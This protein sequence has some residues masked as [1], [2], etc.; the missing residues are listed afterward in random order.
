MKDRFSHLLESQC[1]R[2]VARRR[3]RRLA[4]AA[5]AGLGLL[6]LLVPNRGASG[7]S[8]FADELTLQP[9][10]QES[11]DA[12]AKNTPTAPGDA[13]GEM[14]LEDLMNVQVTSVSR[15]AQKISEA[16]AA[17]TVITQD[18]I[19]RWG[20]HSIP[21][22]LRLAPGMSVARMDA[23]D[24]AIS[25]RG[26][27]DQYANKLLV[28]V[29]G[30]TVY[31][32]FYAGV[33]WDT[34]D[35]LMQDLERIE[36]IRGPGATLWGANA[37]NG[38]IN[39]QTKSA[40]DTQGVLV[41]GLGSN[42]D[43]VGAARYGGKIDDDTFFRLYGQFRKTEEFDETSGRGHFDGWQSTRGGFRI[44]RYGTDKDTL[45]LEG[46]AF[47]ELFGDRDT[48]ANPAFVPPFTTEAEST[49]YS[50]GQYVLG[51]WTHA[52]SDESEFSAQFY[53]DHFARQENELD[54]EQD[55]IDGEFQHRFPVG[56]IQSII[57]GA[58]VRFVS[59]STS[60]TLIADV[61][62]PNKQHYRLA[63]FAQDDVTVVPER[64]HFIVG[65]K[66]EYSSY[67]EFEYQPSARV[68]WTPHERH[69]VW[70]AIS[71]AVHTPTREVQDGTFLLQEFPGQGGVP[72]AVVTTPNRDEK[73]EELLAYELGYRVK[74]IDQ[75]TFDVA[76]FFNHYEGLR[77]IDNSTPQ[78]VPTPSPHVLVTAPAG[79][80][81]DA[82]SY[83]VEVGMNLNITRDWL[84]AA[85]YSFVDIRANPRS[86]ST[87]TNNEARIEGSS[88]QNQ[89]Q[90]HTSYRVTRDLELN[91]SAY[92]V[93]T[94]PFYDIPSY[95]RTDLGLSWRPK[96][97]LVLDVGVQNLFDNQHPEFGPGIVSLNAEVPRTVYAQLTWSF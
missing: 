42:V 92:Y 14:S 94:L 40:R 66:F 24:W 16:P 64:L 43:D 62:P 29:D 67:S 78:F 8:A 38:V 23:N 30:R 55:T 72:T 11:T 77:S 49:N 48:L 86:S 2:K 57:W 82:D 54:F 20:L 73:S 36:V 61:D 15:H 26:F 91:A 88:P 7:R 58:G 84:L 51:R 56:S 93:E 37:V 60:Q 28:L 41:T 18:D 75:L 3:R 89:A 13:L 76:T 85:S 22:A 87:D 5:A 71:R 53:Y 19:H 97:G 96:D 70:G 21:E 68:L 25:A 80:S 50:T 59:D 27:N 45:T 69:T 4:I 33:D 35:Y 44:D 32:P 9:A 12:G 74:P 83:G 79:N 52:I 1:N 95:V 10:T 47:Q 17:V 31:V 63:A 6:A 34:Q 65:S 81:I 90:V 39:I 46:E